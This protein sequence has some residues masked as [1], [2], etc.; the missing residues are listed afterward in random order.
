MQPAEL[1]KL[2][3]SLHLREIEASSLQNRR[4]TKYALHARLL[5]ELFSRMLPHYQV[6]EID[7]R[8]VNAYD[9]L[10]LDTPALHLYFEHH[11][12][13][14]NRCKIRFRTY[15]E[16]KLQFLEIKHRT[17]KDRTY[18]DRLLLTNFSERLEG[19]AAGFLISNSAWKPGALVPTARIRYSRITF[20][21][22]ES[23]ER[24]TLD[25]NLHFSGFGGSHTTGDL[26]IAEL[27]QLRKAH[28][29]FTN[30]AAE[31]HLR[32]GALSKYCHALTSLQ[33]GLKANNFKAQLTRI[34]QI[35]HVS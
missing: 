21:G 4:E 19:P 7:G 20:I 23:G 17:N 25:L 30:I 5:P 8:R 15:T 12:G 31:M 1:V 11:Q 6:L 24:I 14:G 29:P 9:T 27:K 3:S 22:I 34:N 35:A 32:D 13:R 28:C 18:K 2:F 26:V 33:P 16:S 10:Y